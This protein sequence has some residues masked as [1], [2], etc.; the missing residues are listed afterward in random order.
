MEVSDFFANKIKKTWM[1]AS[2]VIY[3]LQL[4]EQCGIHELILYVCREWGSYEL[5]LI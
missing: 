5:F 2:E 1:K 4:L 3:C